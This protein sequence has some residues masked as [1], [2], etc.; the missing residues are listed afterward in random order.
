MTVQ[1]TVRA[2]NDRAAL[3]GESQVPSS[4]PRLSSRKVAESF[5]CIKTTLYFFAFLY[6]RYRQSRKCVLK[7]SLTFYTDYYMLIFQEEYLS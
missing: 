1:W 2:A 6:Y 4:A 7:C 3:R 5:F